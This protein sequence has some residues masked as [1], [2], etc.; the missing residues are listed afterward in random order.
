[1]SQSSSEYSAAGSLFCCE[2]AAD[3]VTSGEDASIS[4]HPLSSCFPPYL[5]PSDE[6]TIAELIDV[7]T[8]HMPNPDYLQRLRDR[9]IDVIARQ[10]SINWI[11][12]V[13]VF[14]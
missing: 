1:M 11:L 5:P 2:D 4:D 13:G 10:N 6:T 9:S 3:V 8:H 12:K 14:S 7:E